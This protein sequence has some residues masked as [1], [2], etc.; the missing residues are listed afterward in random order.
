MQV[1]GLR[2]NRELLSGILRHPEFLAGRTD[3]HFLERNEPAAIVA[4]LRANF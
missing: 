2:T 3:T 4:G 1:H